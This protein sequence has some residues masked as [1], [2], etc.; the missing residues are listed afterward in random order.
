MTSAE[1]EIR[2]RPLGRGTFV[3]G[4]FMTAAVHA[5]LGALIYFAHA[6]TPPP[7]PVIHD[8]MITRIIH[9]GKPPDKKLLPRIVETPPPAAPAPTVKVAE[10]LNA[11]P[12][13]KE[14]PR[15]PDPQ[16]AKDVKR[17]IDRA[18]ALARHFTEE[19]PEGSLTGSEQGTSTEA[20]VGEEYPTKVFEAIRRHWSVPAG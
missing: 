16:L 11:A 20:S 14:P 12:A 10:N 2:Y 19:P 17:A 8:L 7:A 4:V 3:G 1:G 15:P 5:A 13:K 6:N 18:R 9:L